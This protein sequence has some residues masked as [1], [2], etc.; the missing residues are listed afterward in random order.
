MKQR[1]RV[2]AVDDGITTTLQWSLSENPHC[3][4]PSHCFTASQQHSNGYLYCSMSVSFWTRDIIPVCTQSHVPADDLRT[5][6]GSRR[7]CVKT[8]FEIQI[9]TT[10]WCMAHCSCAITMTKKDNK[11]MGHLLQSVVWRDRNKSS[12]MLAW[13]SNK[14]GGYSGETPTLIAIKKNCLASEYLLYQTCSSSEDNV[15]GRLCVLRKTLIHLTTVVPNTR[16]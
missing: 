9:Q 5:R 8:K 7:A 15:V 10:T 12:I 3:H 14:K 1:I 6:F 16:T 4:H 13:Q 11:P 2:N